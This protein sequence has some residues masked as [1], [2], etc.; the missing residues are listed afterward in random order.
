MSSS[1]LFFIW[2]I[3]FFVFTVGALGLQNIYLE[4]LFLSS[5]S[6]TICTEFEVYKDT[7]T[8]YFLISQNIL[9]ILFNVGNL[10][11]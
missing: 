11:Q 9:Q 6:S 1:S 8:V 10:Y 5:L 3:F 7:F 2:Y 4:F